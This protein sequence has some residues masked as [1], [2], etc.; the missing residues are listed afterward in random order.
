MIGLGRGR[1]AAVRGR[2]GS[3]TRSRRTVGKALPGLGPR[4]S[5]GLRSVRGGA[6]RVELSRDGPWRRGERPALGTGGQGL[7][8]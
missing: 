7:R 1:M 3:A 8:P 2:A 6:R 5:P 4:Q